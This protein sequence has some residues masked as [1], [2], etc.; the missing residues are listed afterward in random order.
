[1]KKMREVLATVWREAVDLGGATG[2]EEARRRTHATLSRE[3]SEMRHQWLG[4]MSA[5]CT[6]TH[7]LHEACDLSCTA[8]YLSRTAN[9]TPPLP[10][11]EA[12]KQLD[13]IRAHTGP[14]GS[15]QLT[16]GE[17]TLLPVED[18]ARIVRYA[19]DIDLDP[20]VMSHG[21]TFAENPRYLY[22]L[23]HAGLQKVAI[24]IDSTQRGRRGHTKNAREADLTDIRD[25]FA[26]L[27]REARRHTGRTLHAAHTVT[28]TDDNIDELPG[29][30][31]W[32]VRS[33]DAFRIL[34][35]QPVADVGRTRVSAIG[36]TDL[37]KRV[38]EG[39]GLPLNPHTFTM[40]HPRC[41]GICLFF[42][43]RFESEVRIVE[44]RRTGAPIDARFADELLRG[45]FRGF[46]IDDASRA[47]LWGR[48]IGL[49]ARS[50][51][52]LWQ[53]P[54]YS[55]YRLVDGN[56]TWLF[57]F[58]KTVLTRGEWKVSPA[59]IV[60]HNFM[61]ESELH[62]DEAKQRLAACSFK[63]PVEG[64]MVSMCE[65]N[66]TELRAEQNRKLQAQTISL[67]TSAQ[68]RRATAKPVTA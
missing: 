18:L 3:I 15:V 17:V 48:F 1:M 63:V 12:K 13:E 58:M 57:R 27:I 37:W 32:F 4:T 16:A 29:V 31:R 30:V 64:R 51:K 39:A 28:I 9:A 66:A 5:G 45:A 26:T 67:R 10:F 60:V 68:V 43:V 46:H 25:E 61:S 8:C 49:F 22:E 50:P 55:L 38:C 40:G 59:A 65:F 2:R 20:M 35:L 14:A 42:V 6:A 53:W 33:T 56:L 7:G 21:Q 54:G 19:R 23:M 24:H 52:Y 36:R 47:A 11:A 62:T 34:S 44:V 41:N